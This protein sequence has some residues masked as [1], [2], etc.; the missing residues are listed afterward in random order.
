MWGL[1]SARKLSALC[2]QTLHYNNKKLPEKV[3]RSIKHSLDIVA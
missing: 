2:E 1:F 3:K